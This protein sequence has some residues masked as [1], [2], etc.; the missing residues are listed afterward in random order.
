MSYFQF[1]FGYWVIFIWVPLGPSCT[2]FALCLFCWFEPYKSGLTYLMFGSPRSIWRKQCIQ[3]RYP[4]IFDSVGLIAK[5][6][7]LFALVSSNRQNKCNIGYDIFGCFYFFLACFKAC[8][9]VTLKTDIAKSTWGI[10][11]ESQRKSWRVL[12]VLLEF[13]FSSTFFQSVLFPMLKKGSAQNCKK[14]GDVSAQAKVPF[15]IYA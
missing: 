15:A 4:Q 10:S 5:K 11:R 12:L 1:T 2:F 14:I 7:T 8:R 13:W 6:F 9:K 3:L